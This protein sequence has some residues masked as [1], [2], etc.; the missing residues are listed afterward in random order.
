MR[1]TRGRHAG[2]EIRGSEVLGPGGVLPYVNAPVRTS[3]APPKNLSEADSLL[4]DFKLLQSA[5]DPHIDQICRLK[6]YS[7]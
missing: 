3:Y 1:G 6:T 5:A 7:L 4:I 2:A